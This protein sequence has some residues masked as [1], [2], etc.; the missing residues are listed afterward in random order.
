MSWGT[1]VGALPGHE[2]LNMAD[3]MR[4]AAIP[5]APRTSPVTGAVENP[6]REHMKNA[7]AWR[8]RQAGESE[9]RDALKD[10]AV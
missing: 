9:G 10:S 2:H 4:A 8:A 5:A 6:R 1:E 7:I 3:Q